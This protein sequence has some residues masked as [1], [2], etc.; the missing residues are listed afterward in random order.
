M[1]Q[2]NTTL[3]DIEEVKKQITQ[4][5]ES[6]EKN[7]KQTQREL[8]IVFPIR[9]IKIKN[10]FEKNNLNIEIL[11]DKFENPINSNFLLLLHTPR[12]I[13][14]IFNSSIMLPQLIKS[15]CKIRIKNSEN[16][17]I[18]KGAII[19]QF[20]DDRGLYLFVPYN[21]GK[22]VYSFYFLSYCSRI[23][24]VVR[25]FY[26]ISKCDL[27][28]SISSIK[29]P[30]EEPRKLDDFITE[31]DRIIASNV[32]SRFRKV[33]ENWVYLSDALRELDN[34]LEKTVDPNYIEKIISLNSQLSF[35]TFETTND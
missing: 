3:I 24:D 17:L 6:L 27:E 7:I 30:A 21:S 26:T 28:D 34:L 13:P 12:R 25:Q 15:S 19:Y 29:M 22:K 35:P 18:D 5:K 20:F 31:N 10:F 33:A 8:N 11:N 14:I 23:R 1:T 2:P 9:N 4:I 16:Q 32:S